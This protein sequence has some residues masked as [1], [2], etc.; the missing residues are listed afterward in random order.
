MHLFGQVYLVTDHYGTIYKMT[1]KEL[2]ERI[3]YDS[4]KSDYNWIAPATNLVRICR[5]PSFPDDC[6]LFIRVAILNCF[7]NIEHRA[8]SGGDRYYTNPADEDAVEYCYNSLYGSDDESAIAAR[9]RFLTEMIV[10]AT[11]TNLYDS[12]Y[13]PGPTYRNL[14]ETFGSS[15]F[16]EYIVKKHIDFKMLQETLKEEFIEA[17]GKAAANGDF[18]EDEKKDDEEWKAFYKRIHNLLK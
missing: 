17:V 9:K 14:R 13:H 5:D 11:S 10:A 18:D 6:S 3:E 12:H 8:N 16:E 4:K 2:K 1:A 15:K 7:A